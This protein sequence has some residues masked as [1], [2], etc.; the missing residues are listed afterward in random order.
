MSKVLQY[1]ENA[2]AVT[3]LPGDLTVHCRNVVKS[4]GTGVGQG[5][6]AARD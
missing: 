2:K 4:Y 6:G 1:E 5:D 3:D